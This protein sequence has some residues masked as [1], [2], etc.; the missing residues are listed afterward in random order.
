M[1]SGASESGRGWA[2]GLT[3]NLVA[4]LFAA[5]TG[6]M[7]YFLIA[8]GYGP[9]GLGV[10]AQTLTWFAIM[11]QV[12]A[13][14]IHYAVLHETAN[15]S[16]QAEARAVVNAGVTVVALVSTLAA[17]FSFAM[18]PVVGSVVESF[19]LVSTIRGASL[20]LVF[21]ALAKVVAAGLNGCHR[22]TAFSS[23][24]A[25]R[26]AGMLL[27]VIW[28]GESGAPVDQ[29]GLA[30]VA[31]ELS[32][33]AAA[34]VSWG[35]VRPS[36]SLETARALAR[37]GT[38]ATTAAITVEINSRI[39]IAVLGVL[40]SDQIVG[41]YALAATGFEGVFQIFVLL[42]N[43]MNPM[44]ALAVGQN[45]P[46]RIDEL[47]RQLR[48]WTLAISSGVLIFAGLLLRPAVEILGLSQ[49]FLD[50]RTPLLILLAGLVLA[51]PLLP[52]DQL[53]MIGGEPGAQSKAVLVS[54]LVNVVLNLVLV[55]FWGGIGAAIGTISAVLTLVSLIKRGGHRLLGTNL[56]LR[57]LAF[58]SSTL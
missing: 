48:P 20:A 22:M 16:T 41:V 39:D 4:L 50:A 56:S 34:V 15:A 27:A 55:P 49:E 10:F 54:L 19:P 11:A 18:A 28:L 35:V 44:V 17:A 26:A 58:R 5:A 47:F 53:L 33:L 42:R 7:A 12:A 24:A 3:W 30:F 37:F 1:R 6:L 52:F 32:A 43:Q 38:R 25:A 31:S 14:G 29:L 45:N 36:R 2:R 51:A 21:H 46:S 57:P 23:V 8:R 9:E 13:L 40:A